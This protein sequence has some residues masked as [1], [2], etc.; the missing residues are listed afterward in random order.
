MIVP[1]NS[2]TCNTEGNG[3]L[4]K[5]VVMTTFSM[6]HRTKWAGLITHQYI[7]VLMLLL[8]YPYQ[9]VSRLSAYL[10]PKLFVR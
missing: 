7:A 4:G 9:V 5:V 6:Q 1:V 10:K 3:K 2:N 8:A